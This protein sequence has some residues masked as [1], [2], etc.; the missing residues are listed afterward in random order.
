LSVPFVITTC[1]LWR[2]IQ[3]PV[4]CRKPIRDDAP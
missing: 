1:L 3:K 4:L 2:K